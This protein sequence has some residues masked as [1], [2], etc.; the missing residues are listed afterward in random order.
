VTLWS[1]ALFVALNSLLEVSKGYHIIGLNK[2]ESN[3][4]E[5]RQFNRAVDVVLLGSSNVFFP[6]VQ[7]ID[8]DSRIYALEV[9]FKEKD[10]GSLKVLNLSYSAQMISDDLIWVDCF[11][12]GAQRPSWII[13]GVAPRDF[14]DPD[15]PSPSLT[16]TCISGASWQR[17]IAHSEKHQVMLND[18]TKGIL[19]RLF[20]LYRK[21]HRIK[22]K[23]IVKLR[24]LLPPS[25]KIPNLTNDD[26]KNKI[27]LPPKVNR[28][29]WSDSLKEY[30]YRYANLSA[31]RMDL[32]FSY[33]ADLLA[34][35]KQRKIRILLV[36]MPLTLLNRKLL[37]QHF[38]SS[39]S[40]RLSAL[41][42]SN[43]SVFL[44]L[45][46]CSEFSD[47]DFEDTVHLNRA[48]AKKLAKV[49]VSE[50]NQSAQSD[51]SPK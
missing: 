42:S 47:D 29:S 46:T 43:G 41:A 17:F 1:I 35:C 48:G 27:V 21:Q 28:M 15:Y 50:I 26:S 38:Y 44:D 39:F 3:K 5:L 10:F 11:L 49:L 16:E 19:L 24:E 34:I 2:V 51:C 23:L 7:L 22:E 8:D 4:I 6:I 25:S 36:N 33:L 20:F 37:P 31:D 12:R 40:N 14:W 45:G 13:L 32:Q 30:S 9:P 18:V